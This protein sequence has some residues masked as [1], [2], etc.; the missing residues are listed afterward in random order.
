[1]KKIA[2]CYGV[3][4]K[5]YF[6]NQINYLKTYIFSS[7]LSNFFAK[8]MCFFFIPK[9]V[10]INLNNLPFLFFLILTS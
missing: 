10:Y 8:I 2:I 1:M 5:L 7:N 4:C 3:Y 6:L 9:N